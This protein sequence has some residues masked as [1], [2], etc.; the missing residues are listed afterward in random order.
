MTLKEIGEFGFIKKISRG[1]LI[2]PESIIK[3][4]GDDAAAFATDPDQVSLITTDLLVERI[5]FL[6]DSISGFDLGY[7][8]L[9][10]PAS[11]L[12]ASP[13]RKTVRRII[14]QPFTTA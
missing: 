4:I 13:S 12:S 9:A 8:S 10:V 6:R 11:H 14:W 2:R 5:H 1:C 3:A 7:K